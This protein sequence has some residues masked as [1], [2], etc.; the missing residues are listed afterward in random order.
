MELRVSD[1]QQRALDWAPE[2]L[3]GLTQRVGF[4]T[5]ALDRRSTLAE[6]PLLYGSQATAKL[7]GDTDFPK[8]ICHRAETPIGL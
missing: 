2:P 5:S 4:R 8:D 7:G 3:A 1:T 6:K